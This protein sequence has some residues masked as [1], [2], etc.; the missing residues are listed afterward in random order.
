[1]QD[2]VRFHVQNQNLFFFS[3]SDYSSM[4]CAG[5]VVRIQEIEFVFTQEIN[6]TWLTK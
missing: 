1:M 6:C 2:L 4:N 3:L 5:Y